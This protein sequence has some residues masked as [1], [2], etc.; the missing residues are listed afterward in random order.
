MQ[1]FGG[2]ALTNLRRPAKSRKIIMNSTVPESR[3]S[4]T[5]REP[6]LSQ[7]PWPQRLKRATRRALWLSAVVGAWIGAFNFGLVDEFLYGN[8]A[9]LLSVP[10]FILSL[11]LGFLLRLDNMLVGSAGDWT[12]G[13]KLALLLA[14]TV[15]NLFMMTAIV[16]W[17]KDLKLKL[18][19]KGP[20]KVK[21]AKTKAEKKSK[22]SAPQTQSKERRGK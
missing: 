17:Y 5:P 9:L 1:L 12:Q 13:Q 3:R 18:G 14:A 11:P 16:G 7:S 6:D 4:D 22:K 15:V 8:G 19:I 10:L 21:K 2:G 20:I